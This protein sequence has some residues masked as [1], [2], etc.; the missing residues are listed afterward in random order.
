VL[1][2]SSQVAEQLRDAGISGVS[3]GPVL[4]H[5]TGVE[6][7]T[8]RQL[9][10]SLTLPCVETSQLP[11]VTC[12]PQNEESA[13]DF[14]G[15]KR[16]SPDA[17]YCGAVKHHP[18][19]SVAIDGTRISEAPDLFL[20]GERFGSGGSSFQLLLASSRFVE[21]VRSQKLRGLVFKA[22]RL[23]GHSERRI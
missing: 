9:L 4:E 12:R 22:V 15:P 11:I 16:Y 20:T 6:I 1:F 13:F 18:P 17:P 2:V 3:F 19:T 10:V 14:P 23:S 5:R 7:S 8:R 21:F